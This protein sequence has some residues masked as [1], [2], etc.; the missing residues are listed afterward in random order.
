MSCIERNY[1]Y[2]LNDNY[3]RVQYLLDNTI[4]YSKK[5]IK[6]DFLIHL[7]EMS[8]RKK[9]CNE[10]KLNFQ[11]SKFLERQSTLPVLNM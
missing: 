3:T 11:F 5:K 7:L 9:S 1:I 10:L 4:K 8:S 2:N 6:F